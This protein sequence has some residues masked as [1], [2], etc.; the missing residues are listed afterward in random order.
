MIPLRPYLPVGPSREDA[1]TNKVGQS[2]LKN[3]AATAGGADNRA[4]ATPAAAMMPSPD[5]PIDTAADALLVFFATF[6]AIG[7]LAYFTGL[8]MA[9]WWT[10]GWPCSVLGAAAWIW[11]ARPAGLP[12]RNRSAASNGSGAGIIIAAI[13]LAVVIT[14]CANRPDAD[15]ECYLGL[16]AIALDNPAAL[17]NSSF[18]GDLCFIGYTLTSFDFLRASLSWFTGLPLLT[19]YYLLWPALI[20]AAVVVFQARLYKQIGVVHLT[21]ALVVFFIVMLSWGDTHRTPANFGFVRMFQGKSA[22]FWLAIPAAM[23]HWIRATSLGNKASMLLVACAIVSGTGFSPTGI[24]AGVLLLGL[25]WLA[26]LLQGGAMHW[27]R[28]LLLL[29]PLLAVYP[30]LIGLT[31]R[32]TLT[33][34]FSIVATNTGTL[35]AVFTAAMRDMILGYGVRSIAALFCV[36]A[37]PFLLR[38]SAAKRPVAIFSVLCSGLFLFPWTSDLLAKLSRG[39]FAWRWMFVI[40]FVP[41]IAVT[42][43]RLAGDA[44]PRISRLSLTAG[45]ALSFAIASPRWVISE[46]NYTRITWPA[47]KLADGKRIH[48]RTYNAS[49]TIEG[50]RLISPATGK[51]L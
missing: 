34:H 3:S 16:A 37:L 36:I 46:A 24:P 40:P 41:A 6:T 21:L 30:V 13:A 43:D 8:S 10:I 31:L 9:Q 2:N 42:V 33:K 15:D 18:S 47:Y 26:T 27:R 50:G 1:P 28:Q 35:D 38:A 45:A 12:L 48:L 20:A 49:T 11:F 25:F 19:S 44:R 32:T 14:L 51:R 17:L 39:S 4:L 23:L 5:G 29:L 22:L 7:H